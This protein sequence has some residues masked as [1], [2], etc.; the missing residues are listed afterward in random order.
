MIDLNDPD[1]FT[2]RYKTRQ[3]ADVHLVQVL[4]KGKTLV[5]GR[6]VIAMYRARPNENE[7]CLNSW[8]ADGRFYPG[9]D[10]KGK[11]RISEIDIVLVEE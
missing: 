9:L 4:P 8:Y 11:P 6:T 5:G 3:G 10:K 1:A 2:K 7:W